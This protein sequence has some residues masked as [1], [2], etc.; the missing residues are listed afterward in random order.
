M[1][2]FHDEKTGRYKNMGWTIKQ[3]LHE[4]TSKETQLNFYNIL[5]KKGFL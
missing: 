2:I 3:I 4:K 1:H 5:V